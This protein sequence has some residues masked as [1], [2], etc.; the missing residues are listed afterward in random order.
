[1]AKHH[2]V[3]TSVAELSVSDSGG[4]GPSV[5][6]IHG[7]SSCKEIFSKQ[8]SEPVAAKYR[9]LAADLPGH[10]ASGRAQGD[11]RQA[12]TI[13]GI[14]GALIELLQTLGA[15]ESV[16]VGW[17]LGGHIA[18][19][20]MARLPRLRGLLLSGTPPVPKTPQ[21]LGEAFLPNPAM[22]LA[23]KAEFTEE[24]A[25]AYCNA[26]Y[27]EN[28]EAFQLEAVRHTDGRAREAV[29]AGFLSG[30]GVDQK[31]TVEGL[32]KPVAIINGKNEPLV[33][34]A[35]LEKLNYRNLWGGKVHLLEHGGHVPFWYT[36]E[37]FNPL[38]AGFLGKAHG[39][40]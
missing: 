8:F 20:M 19:E 30:L 37:Q 34:N 21:A 25:R 6:F 12:Y 40:N 17:S 2:R 5:L 27:G 18:I 31:A 36:A 13:P 28:V 38:L 3:E 15:E 22:G 9:F 10:G 23:G 24:E 16:L 33:N 29:F 26:V 39:S 14:A 4:D 35:F 1:M 32:D 7:N 11:V